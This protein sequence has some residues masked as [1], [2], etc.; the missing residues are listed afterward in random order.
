MS[1]LALTTAA[2]SHTTPHPSPKNESKNSPARLPA[3]MRGQPPPTAAPAPGAAWGAAAA[4][5]APRP[6]GTAPGAARWAAC[7]G[8]AAA[9]P[10]ATRCV[11]ACTQ[12]GW[13]QAG[14]RA[15][16]VG[17]GGKG[18][19]RGERRTQPRG[20]GRGQRR[21]HVRVCLSS[22]ARPPTTHLPSCSLAT[23]QTELAMSCPLQASMVSCPARCQVASHWRGGVTCSV[24]AALQQAPSG[25]AQHQ[26]PRR[27]QVASHPLARR[28]DLQRGGRPAAG[29]QRQTTKA[30]LAGSY[31]QHPIAPHAPLPLPP[32]TS[33]PPPP[34]PRSKQPGRGQ[35][36]GLRLTRQCWK[37]TAAQTPRH[38]RCCCHRRR[39]RRPGSAGACGPP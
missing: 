9:A 26:L 5:P 7:P 39:R 31:K 13:R 35:A 3:H 27:C 14:G 21:A 38:P 28:R 29:T 6:A 18:R 22:C 17:R 4:P 10:P 24:A 32:P 33:S 36:G 15:G 2:C 20:G 19:G 8:R 12:R 1:H 11:R 16:G 25:S 34:P 23:A 30:R 37:W